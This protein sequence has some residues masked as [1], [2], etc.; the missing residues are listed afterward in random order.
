[1]KLKTLILCIIYFYSLS[2]NEMLEFSGD[3]IRS[4]KT[5]YCANSD[6]IRM[7]QNNIY[8]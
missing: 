6:A 3:C 8:I 1:M 7:G 4:F 5:M 2:V